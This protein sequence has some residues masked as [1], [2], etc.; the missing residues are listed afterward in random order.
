VSGG[1]VW[2]GIITGLITA[3]ATLTGVWLTQR[4]ARKMRRLDRLDARRVEQREALAEVLVMGGELQNK[5]VELL[6]AAHKY[7]TWAALGRSQP[8]LSYAEAARLHERALVVARLLIHDEQ[9]RDH[10]ERLEG[11]SEDPLRPLVSAA[12]ATMVNAAEEGLRAADRYGYS[13]RALERL[14]RERVL[15]DPQ[16]VR[17]PW[18]RRG[19][20]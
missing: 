15:G 9:V 1:I 8:F 19:R 5:L 16:E 17:R 14:T 7:P 3:T 2:T 6:F 12:A 20:S 4:H 18:W 10:V 11:L 13:L